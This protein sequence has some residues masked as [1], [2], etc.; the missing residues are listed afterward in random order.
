MFWK[1]FGYINVVIL[2]QTYTD[3]CGDLFEGQG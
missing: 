2:S 1:E 3:F